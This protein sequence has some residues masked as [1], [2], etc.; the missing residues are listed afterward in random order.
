MMR[1]HNKNKFKGK[2]VSIVSV[3]YRACYR[4]ILETLPFDSR[5]PLLSESDKYFG[6]LV[7]INVMFTLFCS[8][9]NVL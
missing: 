7:P 6:F 4:R 5:T 2:F 9:V 8:L 1:F 3:T